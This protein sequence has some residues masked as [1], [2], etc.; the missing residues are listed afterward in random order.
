MAVKT[1]KQKVFVPAKPEEVY[2]AFMDSK[3]HTDFTGSNAE[4]DP[5]EGG[6]FITWDG[7]AT[8]KNLKLIRG[9]LI[10]QEWKTSEW[11]DD[12][13]PSIFELTLKPIKGGTEISMVHSNVPSDQA[14]DYAE[15]WKDYYWNPM[16]DYFTSKP[17]KKK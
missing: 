8:G 1:I 11:P 6:K 3:K 16:L 13:P 10:S 5:K 14:D 2:D 9:K 7:Y 17:E 12:E 15:G 4:I